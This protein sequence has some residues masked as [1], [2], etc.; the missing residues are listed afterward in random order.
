MNDNRRDGNGNGHDDAPFK[1]PVPRRPILR[2]HQPGPGDTTTQRLQNLVDNQVAIVTRLDQMNVD[3]VALG[4]GQGRIETI[5]R[6][7]RGKLESVPE[8]IDETLTHR[9]ESAELRR[10]RGIKRFFGSAVGKAVVEVLKVLL[11]GATLWGIA[12]LKGWL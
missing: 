6:D 1:A 5:L 2:I 3:M 4:L 9:E 11:T 8:I 10:W 7:H 12:K